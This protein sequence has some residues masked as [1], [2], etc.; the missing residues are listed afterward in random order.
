MTPPDD[1]PSDIETLL[2]DAESALDEGDVDRALELLETP[3]HEADAD[4]EVRA[5][6]GLAL[7][8]GG[9]YEDAF[10]YVKEAVAHDPEDVECRGALGV[11]HFHRLELVT[12]EKEL[13]RALLTESDW[14][15]AH[16]WL[17][18]VLEF[19]GRYPEAMV[20]F[21]RAQTL[22]REHYPVPQRISDDDLDAVVNDALAAL[23]SRIQDAV[24]DVAIV[25][26]EYPTEELLRDFDPPASPDLLGLF[27][28]VTVAH[29]GAKPSGDLPETVRVFR[30]N[31][32][33]LSSDRAELVDELRVTLLHEIGHSLGMDE[34]ELEAL[35]LE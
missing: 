25:V 6:Y 16:Y 20:E 22:D 5:M 27:T 33:H 28:G 2:D 8:Y 14:A 1:E 10:E 32:E 11:C 23:P 24:Q 31:L 19:R 9:E 12:A 4:P 26:E 13:R 29:A 34:E 3:A 21:Q 35:G 15:E 17:G 7:Y 18:R 30:R